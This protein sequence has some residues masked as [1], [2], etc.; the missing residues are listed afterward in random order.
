MPRLAP[1]VFR[2]AGRISPHLAT[3]L[4]SCRTIESAQ[5]ELRWIRRHVLDSP[6]SQSKPHVNVPSPGNQDQARLHRARVG[7]RQKLSPDTRSHVRSRRVAPEDLVARLVA[8]RGAGE[9]LQ[10]VL[11]TQPFGDL[12]I[13]CEKGVLI[14][15]P[16]TEA[17]ASMLADLVL[18]SPFYRARVEGKGEE[19]RI[20]D[21][22]SGTG[23]IG[24][25]L[26]ARGMAFSPAEAV[27]GVAQG[28][29]HRSALRLFGFDVES[30]AVRLA[31][32]N[33]LHN[34]R[35][36]RLPSPNHGSAI[37]E[38]ESAV[39]FRQ[40]DIFTDEWMA[41]LDDAKSPGY[42]DRDNQDQSRRIDILV[43]NPPYISQRGFEVDTGRSVRNYEPKI[44]L[45]P[46]SLPSQAVDK[47]CA[48]EDIFYARLL[49]IANVLRPR[50]AVFEVGDMRQAI[51]VV[52]MAIA[53]STPRHH[54]D[55]DKSQK[56]DG[57]EQTVARWDVLEIWR[58]WPDCQPSDTE[59]DVVLVCG[60]EVP[61][62]GS[63]HGRVVFLAEGQMM[64]NRFTNRGFRRRLYAGSS[65]LSE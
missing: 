8:R 48:P 36:S 61:V 16:E 24:L 9:P 56:R 4:P 10:Y 59:N 21:L 31:R 58:D 43:S 35:Q 11:G 37:E 63:G 55:P 27:K 23:C 53:R 1:S 32:R 65:F 44:A 30:R 13:L 14:P 6:W 2:R 64:W 57:D 12:E 19:L 39:T 41:N 17:W 62:R 7:A 33:M 3:L 5:T 54:L 50:I 34:F 42:K 38:V 25:S 40:A 20:L 45:V 18:S 51:R 26:Y 60:R 52:E 29:R 46:S 47:T 28:R 22:C 15:R 49:D